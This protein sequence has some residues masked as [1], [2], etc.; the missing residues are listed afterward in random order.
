PSLAMHGGW[1][2]LKSFENSTA[3]LHMGGGCQGCASSQ[4]TMVEGVETALKEN[5]QFVQRVIDVTDH[6]QGENPY[7]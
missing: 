7:Y 5:F 3:Y 1:I 4:A 6:S 2:E